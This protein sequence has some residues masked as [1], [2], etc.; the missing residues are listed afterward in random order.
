MSFFRRALVTYLRV[1]CWI[2]SFGAFMAFASTARTVW[3]WRA[4]WS[5]E[6]TIGTAIAAVCFAMGATFLWL[7]IYEPWRE[8]LNRWADR[9]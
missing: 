6:A 7:A 5:R 9:G 2:V 4:S 8:R 3:E 1:A